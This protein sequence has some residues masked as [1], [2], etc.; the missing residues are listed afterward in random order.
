M[1]FFFFSREESRIH[2][3]VLGPDGEA[4]IWV[5]PEVEIARN[6]GL[7]ERKLRRAV[8]LVREREDERASGASMDGSDAPTTV[9]GRNRP[10][11]PYDT[12]SPCRDLTQVV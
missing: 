7:D 4:K 5:E 8:E 12:F 2:L 11:F 1:R 3:H 10:H 6:W 9:A